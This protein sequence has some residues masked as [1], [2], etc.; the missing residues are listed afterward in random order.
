MRYLVEVDRRDN[1]EDM[2]ADLVAFTPTHVNFTDGDG[3][4]EV[5]YLA[6]RVLSIVPAAD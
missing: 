4:L 2:G 5:S 6:S 3:N 1:F